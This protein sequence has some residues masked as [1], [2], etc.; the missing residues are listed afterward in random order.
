MRFKVVSTL[1]I[2]LI[3]NSCSIE[4][5]QEQNH[6]L[7]KHE[8]SEQSLEIENMMKSEALQ[9]SQNGNYKRALSVYSELLSRHPEDTELLIAIAN[10]YM[11][12]GNF[13]KSHYFYGKA[14]ESSNYDLSVIEKKAVAYMMQGKLNQAISLGDLI[15]KHDKNRWQSYD[16]IGNCYALLK[17]YDM[18]NKN[19][20]MALKIKPDSVRVINNMSIS[21]AMN[22]NLE[23]A[24]KLLTKASNFD[25]SNYKKAQ[26]EM[27]LALIYAMQGN[28]EKAEIIASKHLSEK[29]LL[30]N[31]AVYSMISKD[32]DAAYAFVQNAI[33]KSN[34]HYHTAWENLDKIQ[35]QYNRSKD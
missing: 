33:S 17:Q 29:E 19:Y 11:K 25:L 6:L 9:L 12:Q 30:N 18:A 28:L 31:L 3:L 8:S 15:T 24:E 26:I 34:Y 2:A 23:K 4:R 27:N 13:D 32:I 22:G 16:M 5:Q 7:H 1:A 20:G 14:I 21:Y 35:N 10:L